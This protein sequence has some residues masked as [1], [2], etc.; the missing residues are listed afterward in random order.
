LLPHLG[1][2]IIDLRGDENPK[3]QNPKTPK[4]EKGCSARDLS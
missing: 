3:P 2:E 1:Q 4:A